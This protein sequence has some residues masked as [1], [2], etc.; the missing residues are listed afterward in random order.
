MIYD[1][2]LNGVLLA[3][4]EAQDHHQASN[5]PRKAKKLYNYHGIYV[6]PRS[7]RGRREARDEIRR[8]R[9]EYRSMKWLDLSFWCQ[10]LGELCKQE[11]LQMLKDFSTTTPPLVGAVVTH[12]LS[13]S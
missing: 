1:M 10:G 9:A 8:I 11:D 7:R 4:Y 2:Q 6:S 3:R 12:S 13:I 5:W